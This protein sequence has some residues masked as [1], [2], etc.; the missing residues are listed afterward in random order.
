VETVSRL[1]AAPAHVAYEPLLAR[2]IRG[3]PAI[4]RIL[5][6]ARML[7][8]EHVV[9]Y[10]GGNGAWAWPLKNATVYDPDEKELAPGA[11]YA[12]ENGLPV[13]YTK[14][15]DTIGRADGVLLISVQQLLTDTELR[16]FFQWAHDHL[17]PGGRVLCTVSSPLMVWEW[18][19]RMERRQ[20]NGTVG[21]FA[22][23][24]PHAVRGLYRQVGW[25]GDRSYCI[26]SAA[27]VNAA[28]QHGLRLVEKLPH[29]VDAEYRRTVGAR[30]WGK[31]YN[32]LVFTR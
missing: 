15:R 13:T 7:D 14:D 18:L 10:G 2:G 32:W 29:R 1:N 19:L 31:F 26:R 12:Q 6:V 17:N 11:A 24:G 23:W 27:F 4:R 3:Q 5:Q 16:D 30:N 25:E 28:E 21:Q 8:L 9:D 20:A 22:V